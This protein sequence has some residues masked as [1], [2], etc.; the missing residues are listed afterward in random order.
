[1]GD[2]DGGGEEKERVSSPAHGLQMP[3]TGWVPGAQHSPRTVH[4]M[5]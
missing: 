1:M 2:V 5:F 4:S 3:S